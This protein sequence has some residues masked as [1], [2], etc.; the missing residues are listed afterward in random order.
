M[1]LQEASRPPWPQLAISL[2]LTHRNIL[3]LINEFDLPEGNVTQEN[4]A[5][6]QRQCNASNPAAY[7]QLAFQTCD[8]NS[9]LSEVGPFR[10]SRQGGDSPCWHLRVQPPLG[11]W[12]VEDTDA[13]LPPGGPAPTVCSAWCPGLFRLGCS[14]LP[15]HEISLLRLLLHSEVEAQRQEP[16]NT[17]G[18]P[19]IL[20]HQT[21][22]TLHQG[23][24]HQG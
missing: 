17:M 23:W 22:K 4:F 15:G 18:C 11:P 3:T 10:S 24:G 12:P 7:A 21:H 14:C 6:M 20:S 13:E 2:D 9:F 16:G 1:R 8:I 19:C 5:E